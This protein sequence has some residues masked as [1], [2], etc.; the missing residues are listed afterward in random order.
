[1]SEPNNMNNDYVRPFTNACQLSCPDRTWILITSILQFTNLIL[2]TSFL[3]SPIMSIWCLLLWTTKISEIIQA[4]MH[5]IKAIPQFLIST[6]VTLTRWM[7]N[8]IRQTT[9]TALVRSQHLVNHSVTLVPMRRTTL[10][11]INIS[12]L[13]WLT[14]HPSHT[15]LRTIPQAPDM[16]LW[17]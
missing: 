12:V 14:I 15:F 5:H 10:R 9:Q 7:G 2:K 8:W 3:L 17:K 6:R 11:Q 1:M 16:F 4:I 13:V